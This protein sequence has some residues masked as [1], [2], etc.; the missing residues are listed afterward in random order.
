MES[1]GRLWI[2]WRVQSILGGIYARGPK[3]DLDLSGSAIRILRCGHGGYQFERF[4]DAL[5]ELPRSFL[6]VASGD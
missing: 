6:K 5:S 1:K 3:G 4:I 2:Q